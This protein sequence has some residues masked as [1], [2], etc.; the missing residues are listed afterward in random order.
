[1]PNDPQSKQMF[2]SNLI[3]QKASFIYPFPL[4]SLP[5]FMF[6]TL[7]TT[8]AFNHRFTEPGRP[9][10][11]YQSRFSLLKNINTVFLARVFQWAGSPEPPK[12]Q[13]QSQFSPKNMQTFTFLKLTSTM[14]PDKIQSN[15]HSIFLISLQFYYTQ[16]K[17]HLGIDGQ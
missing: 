12:E 8:T 5:R 14:I 2:T 17:S 4:C 7:R 11:I 3:Y 15:S 9:F 10:L 13:I 6:N 16:C 1:M